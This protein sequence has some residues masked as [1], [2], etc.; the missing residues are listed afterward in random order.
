MTPPGAPGTPSD[1]YKV[2]TPPHDYQPT[3]AEPG[4]RPTCVCGRERR[5]HPRGQR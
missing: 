1:H 2:D 4:C 5:D 3:P